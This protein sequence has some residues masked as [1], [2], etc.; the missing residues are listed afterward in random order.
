MFS[1][2]NHRGVKAF[3]LIELLVVIA[4]IAI[5]A[6][7]LFPVFAQAR[8]KAR[9]I[10][11]MSNMRQLGLGVA[12]FAQDHDETLPKA[13][14]NDQAQPGE[15][16]GNP[17][18]WG[19]EVVIYPY[20]KS[21]EVYRCPDDTTTGLQVYSEA[22]TTNDRNGNPVCGNPPAKPYN[23][24]E[25]TV[26]YGSYRYNTGN[27]PNGP[28]TATKLAALDQPASAIQIAEGTITYQG[29]TNEFNNLGTG[30]GDVHATVCPHD[31][32]S[33]GYQVG[34]NAAFDRHSKVNT[35]DPGSRGHGLANYVFA[36]GH[37]KAM[38]WDST[39]KRIGPDVTGTATQGNALTPTVWRQIFKSN[40]GFHGIDVCQYVAPPGS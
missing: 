36:D 25:M 17:Y 7:I 26:F 18:C 15:N 3:T 1:K 16:W 27:Q 32:S 35:R 14:F 40:D 30:E 4:I 10:S 23:V 11:C 33:N 22:G 8:E 13:F 12:Q 34:M 9:Q 6:A 5:L 24:G 28:F 38:T 20:I 39:W 21:K 29:D 37:A 2:N 31:V 19:W